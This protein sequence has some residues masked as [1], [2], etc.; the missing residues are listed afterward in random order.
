MT[1]RASDALKQALAA[2]I[3]S[4]GLDIDDAA[5]AKLLAYIALLE[6]WNRTHNLTA[7]RESERMVTHH[8]LDAL[9]T[10]PYLP[11]QQ[12]LRLLD[13]GSGG[14][15]PGI[16]LAIARPAWRVTLLDSNRK[17]AAFL[18]QAVAELPLP[19][20]EVVAMRVEGYAPAAP[21]D[22][23]ISRAFSDLGQFAAVARRLVVACG[24][25]IAMKGV[26]PRAELAALPADFRVVALPV[27]D[28]PGLDGERHLVIAERS[29]AS[30]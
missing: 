18:R 4:L 23:A 14:G 29:G 1:M 13:I 19:N 9:A 20:V 10:L 22:I 21:F 6:K 17:K 16:P 24:K 11:Q 5:Q 12:A 26:Y 27:L 25:L 3:S 30:P 2:G 15:L 28:V 8:L 7:I